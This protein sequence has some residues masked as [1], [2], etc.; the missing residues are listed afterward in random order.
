[1]SSTQKVSTYCYQCVN[2]PDMLTVEIKDGVATTVTPNFD[3]RGLHPADGKVCVKPYGLVQKIYNPN[4][5]LKPL[6]RTNPKKGRDQDPGWVEIEWEEAL[7]TIASR[8]NA[9]RAESLVDEQGYPRVAF[10]TG[11]AATPYFYMGTF[12]SFLAAWG[13]VDQSLGAGGTVKCYHTEHVYGELWHRAFTVCPDTPRCE[14]IV[15]FGNNIDA[16]G[17]VTSVRRHADARARGIKRVQIEPHL[18]ITG[19]SASEWIPI[20]PKTDP[21]FLYAM[22]HV[23]LHER[24]LTDLDVHFLKVR[25]GSPY[26][27]GPNGFFVRD[28]ASKK[29]LIWDARTQ[30]AVPFDTADADPALLGSFNVDGLEQGADGKTW[31]HQG[32]TVTTAFEHTRTLVKPHTPEWATAICDVP[33]ATIRRIANEFVDH[34]RIGETIEF[35]GR[36]LPF[37]PVAVM[38]GKGVNNGWGAFECV[39]ARTVLMTL[40]GGLEVPGGLL[41][42]T[43]HITG[44]DFDRM[45]S[46]VPHPDGFLD[47]PFNPT[48]KEQWAAQPQVRHGH[49]TLI[50][51]IGGGLTSQLMGSTVLTWMRLQGRAADSWGKP[52]PPDLWFVYRCNPNISFSETDKMGETMA[53]FPYTVAFSYTQD[54]TNHFADLVLPEAIDLESTQLIRLGGTHYFEQFWDSQGWVLRQPV[55]KPQGDARDFTWISTELAR[56][57]GLLEAYNTMINMGAAGLPLKTDKYD[58]SLDVT[59]AHSVEETWDAVCRAASADVTDG[60]ADDGLAYFKEKGFRV[61]PFPKINWYLYPRMEDLNLRFELPYQER[62]LRIG[63]ELSARLHEQGVTWWDKQL[64]EY[65]AL[66]NWKDL[67]KLWSDAYEKAYGIRAADYPFWL[68]T[69]RSMQYAWGGNVS[70]QMIREV[71]ANVAGHDGIMINSKVAESMGIEQGDRIE[72]TSPV[73]VTSGRALLRQGVRPDTIVMVGQFGHWKTPY[74]KD[75][76]MPSLNNLVPMNMD[77]VDGTGSAVDAV[78][79]KIKKLGSKK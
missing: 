24:P 69:A 30:R 65:E 1:M 21:A 31:E 38:L 54:E 27:I 11:G 47:Y 15:S 25:T 74:A 22:L 37:R 44:M 8:L 2:G 34:A 78:L 29:P 48:D 55:V 62:I 19:A 16:S 76:D 41:G 23:L 57:T 35:E 56:R 72:V 36:T 58:F 4:R 13:P 28:P 73:G 40:V 32:I 9:I 59:R 66:P 3:A 49:T 10:T 43:V 61:K 51:I 75:L 7:D 67:N 50:P 5:L 64:H 45:A 70:L 26:L 52:K 17:G 63:Q 33:V 71:A 20:R 6:K 14:Y 68:L 46:V 60:Q 12:A 18:S 77:L 42:S 53:T 79:V 39:W